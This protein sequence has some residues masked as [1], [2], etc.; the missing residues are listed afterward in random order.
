MSVE[1]YYFYT[2]TSIL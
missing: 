1:P 2:F